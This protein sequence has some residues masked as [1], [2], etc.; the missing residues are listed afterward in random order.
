MQDF[1]RMTEN[2]HKRRVRRLQEERRHRNDNR[3]TARWALILVGFVLMTAGVL[4]AGM[5]WNIAM[6]DT[7]AAVSCG[8]MLL[9]AVGTALIV[10]KDALEVMM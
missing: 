8:L 10:G 4:L 9:L 5:V 6:D 3:E 7:N 1:E 2:N